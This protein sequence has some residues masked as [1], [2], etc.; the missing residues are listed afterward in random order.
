MGRLHH[1]Q[2]IEGVSQPALQFL[3]VVFEHGF[4]RLLVFPSGIT[5]GQVF[6]ALA[7]KGHFDP[8]DVKGP[9]GQERPVV[10]KRCDALFRTHEFR[11]GL[12]GNITHEL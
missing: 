12:I 7:G 4:E 10:T 5:L 11:A 6:Y 1:G 8:I 9:F 2:N 3:I